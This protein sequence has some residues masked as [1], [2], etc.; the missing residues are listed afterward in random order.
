VLICTA[1]WAVYSLYVLVHLFSTNSNI[2][3]PFSKK[4]LMKGEGTD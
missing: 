4:Y 3:P 2:L 1:A